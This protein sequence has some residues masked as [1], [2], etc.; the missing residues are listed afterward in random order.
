MRNIDSPPLVIYTSNGRDNL[1]LQKSVALISNRLGKTACGA[2][3]SPPG[4]ALLWLIVKVER[5]KGP[6]MEWCSATDAPQRW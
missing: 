4:A 3:D 2:E 1:P 5:R 6:C